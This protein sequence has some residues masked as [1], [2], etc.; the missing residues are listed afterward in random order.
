LN[1]FLIRL[2]R[3]AET[4]QFVGTTPFQAFD[5]RRRGV[6]PTVIRTKVAQFNRR[7][8]VF[9]ISFGGQFLAP[10]V[11]PLSIH[12]NGLLLRFIGKCLGLMVA[13]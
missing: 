8:I 13:A 11:G 5:L 1:G 12:P 9:S 4:N 10:I 7:T 6:A 3:I 2:E